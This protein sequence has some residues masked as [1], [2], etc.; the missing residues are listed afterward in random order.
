MRTF[1]ASAREPAAGRAGRLPRFR[2]GGSGSAAARRRQACAPRS[3][4]VSRAPLDFAGPQGRRTIGHAD[5]RLFPPR[6]PACTG[7][8]HAGGAGKRGLFAAA[9]RP[10]A[11]LARGRLAPQSR[12]CGTNWILRRAPSQRSGAAPYSRPAI[13]RRW[14]FRAFPQ[15]R[16]SACAAAGGR[17]RAAVLAFGPLRIMKL[18]IPAAAETKANPAAAKPP[19]ADR[20]GAAATAAAATRPGR[21][22]QKRHPPARLPRAA[23]G[24]REAPAGAGFRGPAAVPPAACRRRGPSTSGRAC[25]EFARAVLRP[26][27]WARSKRSC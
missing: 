20:G 5:G 15:G 27:P 21:R 10:R 14:L 12:R 2:A 13:P 17:I 25:P 11:L 6:A 7:P 9:A 3:L 24:E 4:R 22:P 26:L 16:R 18:R 8:R 23:L 1:R 19:R